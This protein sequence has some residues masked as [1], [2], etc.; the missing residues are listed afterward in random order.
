MIQ[1]ITVLNHF[2]EKIKLGI[3][4]NPLATGLLIT[5]IDG[6]DAGKVDIN[7]QE[8]G[9]TDGG[10]YTSSRMASRNIVMDITYVETDKI[11]SIETLRHL[12]YKFFGV[13]KPV[14]LI[15][16]TDERIC[17]IEGYVES[18]EPDIFSDR[19]S[20]QIS[21]ICPQPYFTSIDMV[22][23]RISDFVPM[24]EFPFSN[25]SLTE[26]LINF[27]EIQTMYDTVIDYTGDY[28]T[29][30]EI[31]IIAK[32]GEVKNFTIYN[33]NTKQKTEV[34]TNNIV[35]PGGSGKL[36]KNDELIIDTR[37][38]YKSC[39]LMRKGKTFNAIRCIPVDIDWMVL[40]R[41]NNR[42]TYTAEEGLEDMYVYLK[43]YILYSGV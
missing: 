30:V 21:I 40:A 5:H 14:T 23:N 26:K 2:G 39:T 8:Y 11:H 10:I 41:G 24:F 27:G 33:A 35:A 37:V 25:E 36:L 32:K 19:E 18:N 4:D 20:T 15:I 9:I 43:Y 38:G 22:E 34:N 28:D 13:K 29:G 16:K 3:K 42:I 6:L 17:R 12:S 7:V 1:S 31:H